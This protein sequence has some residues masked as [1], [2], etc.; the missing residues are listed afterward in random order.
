[1]L[2]GEAAEQMIREIILERFPEHAVLG[3]EEGAP[4]AR[5]GAPLWIVDPLDGT[6]LVAEGLPGSICVIALAP[7]GT[8]F[9]PTDSF[10]MDKLICGA[11]GRGVVDIR[12]PVAEN[13]ASLARAKGVDVTELT[14]VVLD[15]PRHAQLTADIR[16]AGGTADFLATVCELTGIDYTKKNETPTGRP[17]QIVDKAKPFTSLV[18]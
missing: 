6:R 5:P 12:R 3:E 18:V 8:M 15:K 1:M 13:L 4:E 7:R 10:Y 16:S 11:V 9:V 2:L 14:I 17:I